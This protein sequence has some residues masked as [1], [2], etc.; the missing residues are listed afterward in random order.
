MVKLDVQLLSRSV[1]DDFLLIKNDLRI[2]EF[3]EGEA[4]A[5]LLNDLFD[6]LDQKDSFLK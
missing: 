1:A 5:K 2:G 3:E 4:T 6:I